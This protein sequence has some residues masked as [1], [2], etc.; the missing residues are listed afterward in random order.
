MTIDQAH[1]M[2]PRLETLLV[3]Q[4]RLRRQ[5]AR[6]QPGDVRPAV[7]ELA[8]GEKANR[9]WLFEL[10]RA[11]EELGSGFPTSHTDTV[12]RWASAYLGGA[13]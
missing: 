8:V 13:A 1:S 7:V 4:M 12:E 9:L 5:C 3:A 6:Q 2:R 10:E 11:I